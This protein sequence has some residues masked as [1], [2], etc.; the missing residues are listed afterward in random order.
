MAN[1]EDQFDPKT[2]LPVEG[3]TKSEFQRWLMDQ[4]SLVKF[5]VVLLHFEKIMV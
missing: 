4:D 2:V 5:S 3:L 1:D